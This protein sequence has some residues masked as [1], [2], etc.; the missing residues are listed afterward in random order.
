MS[1]STAELRHQIASANDLQAVVR[2][3][4]A[5][6]A[7]SIHQYEQSVQALAAYRATVEQGLGACLRDAPTSGE[8]AWAGASGKA[9]TVGVIVFGSDQGLVGRFNEIIVDHVSAALRTSPGPR[10]V[11]AIGDRVRSR[12][13]DA[14]IAVTNFHPLPSAVEGIAALVDR[15]LIDAESLAS[16]SV[17]PRIEVFHNRPLAGALYEPVQQRLLPLD[18]HW[19]QQLM[20]Q[21]WPSNRRPQVLGSDGSALRSLIREHLFISMFQACAESLASENASRLAAMQRADQNIDE[22]LSSLRRRFQRRRQSSI[23]EELFDLTSGYVALAKDRAAV[24]AT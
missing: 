24:S 22:L 4:R 16:Q 17:T 21:A 5:L 6:A 3:M 13:D 23:D 1:D 9:A 18:A 11:W 7:S 14:G 2:T 12:L 8:L 10:Q 19:R 20:R 15:L